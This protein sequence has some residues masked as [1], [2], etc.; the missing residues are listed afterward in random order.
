MWKKACEKCE[1]VLYAD[2][3]LT[4]TDDKTDNI[5]D[6]DLSKDMEYINAWLVMRIK[7]NCQRLILTVI[8]YL[9]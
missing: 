2:D 9:K 7:P 8:L 4:F 1:I 5:C 3:T 6:E